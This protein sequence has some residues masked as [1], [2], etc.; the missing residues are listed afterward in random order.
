MPQTTAIRR[1]TLHLEIVD[2]LRDM[3]VSGELGPGQKISEKELCARFDIS[4]TPV[5]EALK[6]LAVEGMVELLPQR[7]ARVMTITDEELDELFPIIACI[8]ALAGELACEMMTPSQLEEIVA[9]HDSMVIA[10]NQAERF[11]YSRLNRAI[12]LSIFQSTNNASLLALYRNLELRIRNIRHTVRQK[13]EDWHQAI[14]DHK[15]MIEALTM[16][17]KTRLASIM[18]RH[19]MNTADAVRRS[20]D[21]LVA[22]GIVESSPKFSRQLPGPQ[23]H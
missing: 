3:I 11:E 16:R 14:V 18:R 5:R 4:R 21:E 9:I 15:E 17:D 22:N 23:Q 7:G 20:I 19:V 12:H 13:P 8:E 6:A 1:K 10:Y 2:R